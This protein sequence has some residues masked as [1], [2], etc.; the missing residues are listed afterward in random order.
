VNVDI[1]GLSLY[2]QIHGSGD[3]VLLVH[4][5]PLSGRLWEPITPALGRD[6]RLIVPDLRG[7]GRSEPSA[8]ASMS[9]FADDLVAL[10][11]TIGE[12][13]P[14]ALV[15][16]SMGGYIAFEFCRR[17]PDRLRALVLANT[18]AQADSAEEAQARR[19]TAA[20]VLRE[21]SGIVA[22][23]MVSRLFGAQASPDLRQCWVERMAGEDPLGV[24]AALGAMAERP[25]SFHTLASTRL[26]MLIV[27]GE[28]DSLTPLEGARRMQQAAPHA[29]LEVIPEA[30]HMSPVEQP[31]R[32]AEILR[33]FLK[34]LPPEPM[35]G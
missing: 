9:R 15:G 35:G 11:D 33:Q 25:D 2:Y 14:V 8:S 31:G 6:F 28:D 10:L 16:M 34:E 21:G 20:R 12:T 5:F 18:R 13:R 26:P 32:F 23:A 29:R 30:G 27:A 4:G 17:R 22:Q 24:A 19:E 3:P 7:L 1:D